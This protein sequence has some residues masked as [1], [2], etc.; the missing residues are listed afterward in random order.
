MAILWLVWPAGQVVEL[1]LPVG[2]GPTHAHI[3]EPVL[4]RG[5]IAHDRR[6]GA[7]DQSP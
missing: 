4:L 2:K 7:R 6:H 1:G 5:A 3:R